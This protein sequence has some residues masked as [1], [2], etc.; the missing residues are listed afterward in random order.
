MAVGPVTL[1][2]DAGLGIRGNPLRFANQDDVPFGWFYGH[3]PVGPVRLG[4]RLGGD[5][6]TARNP[7]RGS[8]AVGGELGEHLRIGAEAQAGLTPAAADWGA[9]VWVGGA[10]ACRRPA[11]D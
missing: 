3:V 4:A 2:L 10:P 7:G 8:A 9:R 5:A 6:P 11:R 1:G